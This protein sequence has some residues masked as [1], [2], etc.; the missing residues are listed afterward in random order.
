MTTFPTTTNYVP[1]RHAGLIPE[2][3]A[4]RRTGPGV[5]PESHAQPR[6]APSRRIVARVRS[7][8]R[9]WYAAGEL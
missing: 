6:S 4:Y 7:A 1:Q 3:T 8:F 2:T 9:T 5:G